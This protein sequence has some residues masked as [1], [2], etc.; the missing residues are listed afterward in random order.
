MIAMLKRV[1]F[2]FLFLCS[3]LVYGQSR[4]TL[5]ALFL[6]E[7]DEEFVAIKCDK[8]WEQNF[9][10]ATILHVGDKYVMYYRTFNRDT[11][12][13]LL[14]CYAESQDGIH[15]TK[16]D[17]GLYEYAGDKRNN[18]LSDRF[19]GASFEYND[20]IYY[21]LADRMYDSIDNTD[22]KAL[23]LLKSTDGK[24]FSMTDTIPA[25]LVCDTHN[26][27]LWDRW[28]KTYKWYLRSWSLPLNLVPSPNHSR[29]RYR[30]VSFA[31]T[32]Q[33]DV[34][35]VYNMFKSINRKATNAVTLKEE[36]PVV[37]RNVTQEDYDIYTPCVHQYRKDL[38]I[39]YPTYYYHIPDL[40]HGGKSDNNGPGL[41]A[42]WVST[43]GEHFF[44]L[45]D[46]YM[47]NGDN[48]LE[49]CIGHVETDTCFI[50][51]YITFD[52]PHRGTKPNTIKGRIHY[53]Q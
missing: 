13:K 42:M 30:T 8:D 51:Y 26:E 12:T 16:P 7:P 47:T 34:F 3:S 33:P 28:T 22:H 41:V 21:M 53:K 24:V 46:K 19:N 27:L 37:M 49:Y 50:H 20:G 9:H 2:V 39:A 1:L 15:W 32:K 4:D 45:N 11:D 10:Y 31:E 52:N 43:D 5:V 18:I 44:E 35:Q 36:L 48:W 23:Y 29:A 25:P 6:Q 38:Y 40:E 14:Y 17:L